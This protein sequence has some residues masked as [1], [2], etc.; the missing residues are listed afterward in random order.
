MDINGI[1][2]CVIYWGVLREVGLL[3][4]I[5]LLVRLGLVEVSTGL[6]GFEEVYFF[7]ISAVVGLEVKL[8]GVV[9]NYYV[10]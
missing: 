2:R 5:R 4:V 3:L 8:C 6:E 10:L 1:R 7:I 9:R